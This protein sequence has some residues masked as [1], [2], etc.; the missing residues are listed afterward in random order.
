MR[1]RLGYD[2][3]MNNTNNTALLSLNATTAEKVAYY[4]SK[5]AVRVEV[6]PTDEGEYVVAHF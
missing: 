2:V 3:Y 1:S 5:G 6:I 4:L